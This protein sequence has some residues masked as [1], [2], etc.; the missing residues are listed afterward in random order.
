MLTS[1]P[2]LS[3]RSRRRRR[4]LFVTGAVLAAILIAALLAAL[5]A[6]SRTPAAKDVA[7]SVEQPP[8]GPP[9]RHGP[10]TARFTIVVYAD[11]ECPFCQAYVPVLR[12]WI[13][14][15][16]DV[17]LQWHHLPLSLHEPAAGAAARWAE[18]VGEAFGHAR[19]WDAVIWFYQ[20]TR[21]SG[22]GLSPGT[23][24]PER[25]QAVSACLASEHPSL[26]V[27]TQVSQARDDGIDGTP[28]LRLID[29]DS[30]RTMTLAGP[31]VGDALLSALDLL[32][33]PISDEEPAD[34]Q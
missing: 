9:W 4:T 18:C 26:A 1:L 5:L 31:V 21:G 17:N 12:A 25:D 16:P 22:Q 15:Q 29:H 13:D 20:H 24:F 6:G 3:S 11:L 7:V 19:F 34:V 8:P 10:V 30:Q 2:P 23:E 32:A 33:S 14:T 28:S 27:A